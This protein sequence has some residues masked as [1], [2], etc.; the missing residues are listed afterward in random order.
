LLQSQI[1]WKP[2]NPCDGVQTMDLKKLF[3]EDRAVSPVIGVILMVAITVILAAV[4][5]A[6][7]LGL[8][9]QVGDTAPSAQI[10][11]DFDS[12]ESVTLTHDGGNSLQVSDISVNINGSVATAEEI[13]WGDETISAG[14]SATVSD[15]DGNISDDDIESGNTVRVVWQ[16]SSGSSSTI[17]QRTIP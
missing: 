6:F 10:S 13:S 17:A 4:I 3:T 7:V 12:N 2:D 14:Q 8:G 11:F 1:T 15:G 9:D 16:G 5:G